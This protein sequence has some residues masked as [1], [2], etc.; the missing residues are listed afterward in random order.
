MLWCTQSP[1]YWRTTLPRRSG[2]VFAKLDCYHIRHQKANPTV[3][4]ASGMLL[5]DA[6]TKKFQGT[7]MEARQRRHPIH[8]HAKPK[9]SPMTS[10]KSRVAGSCSFSSAL[11]LETQTSV[12]SGALNLAYRSRAQLAR[13]LSPLCSL[14]G[15]RPLRAETANSV[16]KVP[17]THNWTAAAQS[18]RDIC[19]GPALALRLRPH[20]C[21]GPATQRQ[22]PTCRSCSATDLTWACAA[23]LGDCQFLA[24]WLSQPCK[25]EGQAKLP[26][27]SK[28]PWLGGE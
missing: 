10:W 13:P 16:S 26:Q 5:A 4:P 23:V 15:A 27:L 22:G 14:K 21:P 11:A 24:A 3:C 12:A 18:R 1:T 19:P 2:I 25:H 7:K 8:K 17:S 9:A 28:I 20:S 6:M